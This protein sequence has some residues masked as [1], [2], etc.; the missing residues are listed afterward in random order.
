MSVRFTE[1]QCACS[2]CLPRACRN[3]YHPITPLRTSQLHQGP[4]QRRLRAPKGIARHGQHTIWGD[5]MHIR[6]PDLQHLIFGASEDWRAEERDGCQVRRLI[7]RTPNHGS[8]R[9]IACMND[10]LRSASVGTW[11]RAVWLQT[12]KRG[13]TCLYQIWQQMDVCLTTL[14]SNIKLAVCIAQ[15]GRLLLSTVQKESVVRY[16]C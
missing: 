5:S 4:T 7:R 6:Q 15:A 9:S 16:S 11:G 2:D 3:M 1:R 10:W 13:V 14:I 8:R 12:A